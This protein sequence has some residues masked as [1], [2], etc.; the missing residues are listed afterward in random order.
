MTTYRG[1]Y[2]I[3]RKTDD[4]E[5]EVLLSVSEDTDAPDIESAYNPLLLGV[6]GKI[7]R[8]RPMVGMAEE[9]QHNLPTEIV[10]NS[11]TLR[12]VETKEN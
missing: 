11:P 5:Y 3:E 9:E 8:Y 2:V 10:P 6:S 4:G 12:S 1:T 7:E